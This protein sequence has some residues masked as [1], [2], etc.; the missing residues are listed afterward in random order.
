MVS[1]VLITLR[2]IVAP[3]PTFLITSTN[4]ALS[5]TFW[6]GALPWLSVMV[7][8]GLCPYIAR[9]LGCEVVERLT[10]CM[11]LRGVDGYF[12]RLGP[13]TIPVCCLLPF[14]P[15]DPVSY[16]A[17]LTLLRFWFSMLAAGVGQLS[18]TIIYSWA[19]SLLTGD[20]FWLATGPSL[21][22]ALAMVI[23]IAKDTY[24]EHHKRS[25]P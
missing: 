4:V 25:S 23:S 20:I 18:A 8:A 13:Q 15:F 11:I 7:R 14:V 2:A 5:G 3:L 6:D 1:F 22:F 17:G 19:G 9:T 21:L 16:A 10:G 24:R 12:T